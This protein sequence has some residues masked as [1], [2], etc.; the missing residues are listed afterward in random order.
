MAK[1]SNA[2][3]LKIVKQGLLVALPLVIKAIKNR[4]GGNKL[5]TKGSGSTVP[6][7][8]NRP[9]PKP[10]KATKRK[11]KPTSTRTKA[12]PTARTSPRHAPSPI[13]ELHRKK[14]SDAII[15]DR[16]IVVKVLPDDDE[17]SRH[18]RLLVEVDHTDITIKI[19][20]NIDLA[21]RVPARR[22]DRLTFKGEY[23]Y[24]E[25]GGAMHWTHHDPKK[26][27]EGGW[28]DHD[29]KRYE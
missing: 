17:G 21:P 8:S 11:A 23:E 5:A 25:L 15:T 27:R 3:L 19:A 1:K 9:P 7:P 28:I 2:Q 26:W 4:G 20:H 14:Q 24:N 18:Q 13:A 10:G 16:G 6:P 29:G 22:G 12:P